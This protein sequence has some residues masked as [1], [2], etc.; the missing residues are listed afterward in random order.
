MNL[1]LSIQYG[2]HSDVRDNNNRRLWQPSGDSKTIALNENVINVITPTAQDSEFKFILT[3][4]NTYAV[5]VVCTSIEDGEEDI[6]RALVPPGGTLPIS[7]ANCFYEEEP[8]LEF[9]F[10]IAGSREEGGGE[11]RFTVECV[12]G[13]VPCG[14]CRQDTY[15]I[16]TAQHRNVDCRFRSSYMN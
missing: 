9:T 16:C 2:F 4:N 7:D 6:Y 14:C 5:A 1:V 8:Q 13:N 10:D 3:N 15:C 11:L 12:H